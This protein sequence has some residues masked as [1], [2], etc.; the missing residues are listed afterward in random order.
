MTSY[1]L[2]ACFLHSKTV[3]TANSTT[4]EA[5]AIVIIPSVVLQNGVD[6]GGGGR[7]VEVS[8]TAGLAERILNT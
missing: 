3:T 6:G 5:D 2:F 7:V 4:T 1:L 8:G